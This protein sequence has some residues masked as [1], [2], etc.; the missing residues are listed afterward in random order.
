MD[1]IPVVEELGRSSQGLVTTR[2]LTAAG[3]SR[4]AVSRLVTGGVLL[5]LRRRVYSLRPLPERPRHLV[6]DRGVAPE[7]VA[8]VRAE[9]LSLGSGAAACGRTAAAL[10]GWGLLVEPVEV[11]VARLHGSD[12]RRRGL[13]V[14]QHRHSGRTRV[15][16]LPG[17]DRLTLTARVQT[18]VDAAATLPLL[19]AVVL[20]DSA[21][22]SGTVTLEELQRAASRP[23]RGTAGAE[24][25]RQV[26][27]LCDPASG[28]VLES[29][30]R[31][32][33]VLAGLSGFRTQGV[34]RRLPQLRVDF[35]F[36]QARLVVEVD[37]ARWHTDTARDQARDNALAV[38]GWRVLRF[39]WSEVVHGPEQV[40]AAIRAALSAPN[41][42][43][44]VP[45]RAAQAA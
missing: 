28:S 10:Y 40:L 17:T 20:A 19:E 36:E 5:R 27:A 8:Q 9:L 6:T 12:L 44:N 34:L 11:E 21:L 3:L 18:V 33:M 4:P 16:V 31:V 2:Q 15:R 22:R 41:A 14:T 24:R 45:A 32:R 26:V 38:L 23:L 29:L 35:C 30:L 39:T 25:V 43:Q 7:Y 42:V 1:V 13:R 37:G